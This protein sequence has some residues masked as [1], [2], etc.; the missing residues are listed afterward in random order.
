MELEKKVSVDGDGERKVVIWV[1]ISRTG[2][3]GSGFCW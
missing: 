2:K 3:Q 1:L